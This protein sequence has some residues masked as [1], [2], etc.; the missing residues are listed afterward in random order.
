MRVGDGDCK[1]IGGIGA[2]KL[3]AGQQHTQHRL[4]LRLSAAVFRCIWT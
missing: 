3:N 4:H 2:S 1:R